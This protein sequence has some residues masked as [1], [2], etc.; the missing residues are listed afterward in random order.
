M[1]ATD[2]HAKIT[3]CALLYKSPSET[4]RMKKTKV[5]ELHKH[6]RDDR[7]SVNGDPRYG[8]PSASTNDENIERVCS[9]VGNDQ[10]KNIQR[11][12]KK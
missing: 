1:A 10:R 6:S 3:F 8:R 11:H 7:A 5:Y 4:V 2:Q 12:L 9:V